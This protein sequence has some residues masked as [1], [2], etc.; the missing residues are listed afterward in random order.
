MASD[1]SPDPDTPA[2]AT[3]VFSGI[4]TSTSFKLCTLAPWTWIAVGRSAALACAS[5][6]AR[7][8]T[9]SRAECVWST[10]AFPFENSP[11]LSDR[12][13]DVLGA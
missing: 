13:I 9:R 3:R 6:G 11:S 7:C 1:D 8:A 5:R 4:D 10:M 12:E 2:T